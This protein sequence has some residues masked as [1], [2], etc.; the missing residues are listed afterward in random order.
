MLKTL[1]A[2][3]PNPTVKVLLRL[4]ALLFAGAL[5]CTMVFILPIPARVTDFFQDINLITALCV[6]AALALVLGRRGWGWGLV[7]AFFV[8]LL[9]TL[10]LISRWQTG[11]YHANLFGGILPWSDAADYYTDAQQL[12]LGHHFTETSTKRP[13]FAGFLSVLLFITRQNLQV[14]VLILTL[15]VGL[16]CYLLAREVRASHGALAAAFCTVVIFLFFRRYAGQTMTE[17]LGLCL[18]AL[19][20]G[21]I[22]RGARL[23]LPS[24]WLAGL[25]ILS[26]ALM[27]RAGAF[28]IL[29]ALI[30]WAGLYFRGGKR[31]NLPLA[32]GSILAVGAA[33]A[34]NIA[35]ASLIGLPGD[36]SFSNYALTFYGLV[37]G[38]KGYDQFLVDYPGVSQSEAWGL[39]LQKIRQAPAAALNGVLLSYKDYFSTYS[40]GAYTFTYFRG[41][42]PRYFKILM[43]GLS[44]AGLLFA[45]FRRNRMRDALFLCG[46]AGVLA[47]VAL[48][49]P[50]DADDMR[51]YAATI[52]FT[53]FLAANGLALPFFRKEAPEVLP[54]N[55]G[56]A[57]AL[58]NPLVGFGFG[59][60]AVCVLGP[61]V[62]L[63]A[64]AP[65]GLSQPLNCPE[66]RV[67][68]ELAVRPGSYFIVVPDSFVAQSFLPYIRES[69]FRRT[70]LESQQYW[71][72]LSAALLQV[73]STRL[74]VS[75][76]N[77]AAYYHG[78]APGAN[79]ILVAAMPPPRDGLLKACA[80][81]AS[82]QW[83]N[84]RGLHTV[85]GPQPALP[86]PKGLYYNNRALSVQAGWFYGLVAAAALAVALAGWVRTDGIEILKALK[87]WRS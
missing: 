29:P 46:F 28:F 59:L 14:S 24:L 51:A 45:F 66:G 39:A 60:V 68:V 1:A 34:L 42:E 40:R 85:D 26:M 58:R 2:V 69:D 30:L 36:S 18:G 54:S 32:L 67:D 64:G 6:A 23:R 74:V 76:V 21:A 17:S 70:V 73:S 86:E 72:E 20:L 47:S 56:A 25:F 12:L 82:N 55:L 37:A 79:I 35:L 27:A 3:L 8:V 49:P 9:F 65:K 15:L 61:L 71:P 10:P 16:A 63:A 53:A 83:L 48:V 4:C 50:V 77:R 19:G 13:L 84:A 11:F 81:P 22:W 87:K 5:Y 57:A 31:F 41:A 80:V 62:I 78:Q 38:N 75:G 43:W 33:F 7:Q 52:P 44:A